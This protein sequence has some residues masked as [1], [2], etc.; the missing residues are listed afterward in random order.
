IQT[1]KGIKNTTEKL[2]VYSSEI[3]SMIGTYFMKMTLAE[4]MDDKI[5][6]EAAENLKKNIND[7]LLENEY[8][9]APIVY[10]VIFEDW[11]CQ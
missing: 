1:V 4:A 3:K 10:Q 5:K 11:F 6:V 2:E 8:T 7:L 9:K